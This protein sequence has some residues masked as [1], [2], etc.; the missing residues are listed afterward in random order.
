MQCIICASFPLPL[1]LQDGHVT[2]HKT[3]APTHFSVKT[4]SAICL[5]QLCNTEEGL[6]SH[7]HLTK[8]R[9]HL[10][11]AR[12]EVP[13]FLPCVQEGVACHAH[14]LHPENYPGVSL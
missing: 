4:D 1:S 12:P 8:S 6:H 3:L 11:R 13:L 5:P 10:K 7:I 2:D 14:I 9:W